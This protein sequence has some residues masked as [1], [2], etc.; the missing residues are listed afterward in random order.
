MAEVSNPFSKLKSAP[1]KT[2][3]GGVVNTAMQ[4]KGFEGGALNS[5]NVQDGGEISPVQRNVNE[6]KDT[7]SGQIGSLLDKSNPYMELSR[8][9]AQRT[10]NSRGLINSTM[11]AKAGE[12]AAIQSAMPIATQDAATYFDQG[13]TNQGVVNKFL[14]NRQSTELNKELSSQESQQTKELSAQQNT[15]QLA[16]MGFDR[17]SQETIAKLQNDLKME[18]DTHSAGLK[19]TL[20]LVLADKK[21]TTDMKKIFAT[22]MSRITTETQNSIA[23]IGTSDRSPQQ[24]AAAIDQLIKQRDAQIDLLRGMMQSSTDWDWFNSD[25]VSPA[26]APAPEQGAAPPA[27]AVPAPAA[28]VPNQP[29]TSVTRPRWGDAQ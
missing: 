18:S 13:K 25:V 23:Q 20:E 14:E 21:L 3:T 10:A 1:S 16:R 11:A 7:V 27:P 17:E 24:Q 4:Q 2:K 5:E 19:E 22:E 6:Q 28:P 8:R 29:T 12:E 26:P 9:N 15:E